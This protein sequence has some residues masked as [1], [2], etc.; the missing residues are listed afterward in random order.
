[1]WIII[2]MAKS[3]QNDICRTQQSEKATY[4]MRKI[5]AII[6][7]MRGLY[8]WY[9][10]VYMY[11]YIIYYEKKSSFL[12]LISEY[13]QNVLELLRDSWRHGSGPSYSFVHFKNWIVLRVLSVFWILTSHHIYNCKYFFT[14]CRL[15]FDCWLCP[16]HRGFNFDK[17]QFSYFYFY[18]L[19]S[20]SYIQEIS[21]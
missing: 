14:F 19:C 6:Y 13:S 4:I 20:W 10:Y 12:L 16:L 2:K 1:M 3:S 8:I 11:I 18:C 17:V 9:I 5:F 7:M 21:N 15:P